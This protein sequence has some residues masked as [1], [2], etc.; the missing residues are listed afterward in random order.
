MHISFNTIHCVYKTFPSLSSQAPHIVQRSNMSGLY[1]FFLPLL[2]SPVLSGG[3][4]PIAADQ[5]QWRYQRAPLSAK[6]MDD[7]VAMG[8]CSNG[9]IFGP[10]DSRA[11]VGLFTQS[12]ILQSVSQ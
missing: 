4:E 9:C 1:I 8:F 6:C 5:C 2:V 3:L 10:N 12:M 11:G 7:E